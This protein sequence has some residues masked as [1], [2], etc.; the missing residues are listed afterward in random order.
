VVFL[1]GCGKNER[2]NIDEDEFE[3]L[4]GIGRVYLGLDAK[5]V[6]AAIAAQELMEV[7]LGEGERDY[8]KDGSARQGTVA[9]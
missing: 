6:K 2:A 7:D 5:G 4:R 9:L 8:G 3:A 1:Y